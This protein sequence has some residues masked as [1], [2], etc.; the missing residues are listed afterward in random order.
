MYVWVLGRS[1]AGRLSRGYWPSA[2]VSYEFRTTVMSICKQKTLAFLISSFTVWYRALYQMVCVTGQFTVTRPSPFLCNPTVR[3]RVHRNPSLNSIMSQLYPS[4]ISFDTS[5]KTVASKMNG[6]VLND[7]SSNP[8]RDGTFLSPVSLLCPE[9]YQGRP[10]H[11]FSRCGDSFIFTVMAGGKGGSARN[12][13]Y[14]TQLH[15]AAMLNNLWY[16][17]SVHLCAFVTRCMCT[18]V[19]F[20]LFYIQISFVSDLPTKILCAVPI[21]AACL[22]C[23]SLR[24]RSNCI[25]PVG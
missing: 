22:S 21:R 18:R 4:H 19:T 17:A 23:H 24:D 12:V 3:Y 2:A 5:A 8:E 7:W 6:H 10:S 20:T 9:Q 11:Q 13:K 14:T 1:V 25:V 16:C 15:L